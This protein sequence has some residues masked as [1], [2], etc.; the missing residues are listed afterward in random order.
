M[1]PPCSMD[2]CGVIKADSFPVVT[3]Y[4]DNSVGNSGSLLTGFKFV[5][6]NSRLNWLIF[7]KIAF[8]L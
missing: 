4:S 2:L 1:D 7:I 8:L 5:L 3:S 6:W